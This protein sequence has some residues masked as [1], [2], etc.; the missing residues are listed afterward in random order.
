MAYSE[1]YLRKLVELTRVSSFVVFE[2]VLAH[3]VSGA[4][5]TEL[6][7]KY[8]V[9]PSDISRLKA[10]LLKRDAQIEILANLREPDGL[11]EAYLRE[12]ANLSKA[13]N[14]PLLEAVIEYHMHGGHQ[15]ELAAKFGVGQSELS[16]RYKQLLRL[17]DVAMNLIKLRKT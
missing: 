11:T 5:Q 1:S 9:R 15:G 10:R 13:N 7:A 16:R 17:D 3:L 6:A 12:L 14:K 8:C 4:S 2:A